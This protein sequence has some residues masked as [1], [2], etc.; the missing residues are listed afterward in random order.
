MPYILDADWVI[1]ALAGRSKAV[2]TLKL[3]APDGIAISWVTVGEIYE[4]ALGFSQTEIR[5]AAFRQFLH[6]FRV[7]NLNDP[8]M[9]R[10][11][12]IRS[13]LR[14]R[15]ELISDFD[16]LLGATALHHDLT[17]LTYNI[18]HLQRIPDLKLYR[19]S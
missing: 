2:Q 3:L 6:P 5:I 13:L 1:Q 9:E 8:I 12:G 7:L 11:A 4:G 17:V 18:R 19:E 14:R 10:F 16:I 15:G